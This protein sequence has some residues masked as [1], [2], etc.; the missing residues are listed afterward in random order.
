MVGLG[1]IGGVISALFTEWFKFSKEQKDRQH[2]IRLYELQA[3][4]AKEEKEKEVSIAAFDSA[5]K[6]L[7]SAREHDASLVSQ[8]RWVNDLRASVRPFVTYY[9]ITVATIFFFC[10]DDI[11]RQDVL[12]SFLVLMEAVTTFWFTG[13]SLRGLN[14]QR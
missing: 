3:A 12:A 5:A 4:T 11:I 10:G 6:T 14:V 13:R 2:E 8:S 7:I 9:T 1:A